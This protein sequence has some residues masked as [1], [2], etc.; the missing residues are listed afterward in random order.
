MKK[1]FKNYLSSKVLSRSSILAIDILIIIFSCLLTFLLRF[2]F[3]DVTN[4]GIYAQVIILSFTLIIFNT[5]FFIFFKTFGGILRFSSFRDLLRIVFALSG[6]YLVSFL[7]IVVLNLTKV[8]PCFSPFL[9]FITYMINLM[10]MVFSRVI[11]KEVFE[12]LRPGQGKKE[13]VFVY[14]T[15]EVGIRLAKALK[16]NSEFNYRVLGFIT[17]EAFLLGKDILGAKVYANDENIF[18]TLEQ[19]DV[20]KIIISPQKL[21]ELKNSNTL[22]PF[23]ERQI[24]LMTTLP[25]NEW[26]GS[27]ISKTDLKDIQIEDLLPRKP[28]QISL[29]DIANELEGKRVMITGAAGSI[30]SEIVR[31]VAAF[32]PYKLFLIDQAETPLHDLRLEMKEKWSEV[33]SDSIIADVVNLS[34][35]EKIFASTQPDYIF[36][37]AAYKH[38]PMMED[39]VSEAIQ[40]NVGGTKNLADLA[41]KYNAQKFVMISTD[42]AV[43]PTNVMGCSKRIAEIYVQSL[44]K[45]LREE[46]RK[47]SVQFITTRFGNVLGSNGS[48]IPLFKEQIRK[49]G[50]VT[51]THPEIIRYFMTIPEACQLVLQAGTMGRGG[52][53]FVFDMGEPV[54]IFDLA[55]KMIALSGANNIRIK[56]TGLRNGEKLYEELLNDEEMTSKTDHQKIMIAKVR[57]YD[58]IDVDKKIKSLLNVC[59]DYVP[60][61]IVA[62]M[63]EIVPEYK[64]VNS[65]YESIDKQRVLSSK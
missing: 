56:F 22:D 5:I 21:E 49:G 53:I 58:F 3:V 26:R 44:A 4:S 47:N 55:K 31:Q 30:G 61:R 63:K 39:N 59:E 52:E 14:G 16:G 33:K 25:F 42:K 2:G 54:K 12:R 43:N 36:H 51:V 48:V 20:T 19:N 13:N 45:K 65:P 46:G 27:Q 15:K 35:M 34:R 10:L 57:E 1:F 62:E 32:N 6:G 9:I 17:D 50:P 40:T 8:L 38:V 7:V 24:A 37:A 60:M 18:R 11:V 28:I 29:R 23:I 41:V 64:S